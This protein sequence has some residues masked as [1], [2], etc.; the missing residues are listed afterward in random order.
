MPALS[1]SRS[2]SSA[3]VRPRRLSFVCTTSRPSSIG[4]PRLGRLVVPEEDH[5]FLPRP[6]VPPLVQP[7]DPHVAAEH[8]DARLRVQLL[9][10]Q[11][12]LDGRA[13][14]DPAAIRVLRVARPHAL[15]HHHGLEASDLAACRRCERSSSNSVWVMTRRSCAVQVFLRNVLRRA[16]G[17]DHDAVLDRLLGDPL[18][19]AICVLKFPT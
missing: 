9:E 10:V 19:L 7:V 2:A 5:P 15:D 3:R 6:A 4:D 11:G 13:A 1:T 17:D 12:V 8:V 16:R 14:A 18:P